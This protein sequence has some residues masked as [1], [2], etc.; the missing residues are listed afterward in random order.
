MERNI[1]RDAG[2]VE[3][4]PEAV[5]IS[6]RHIAAY[7]QRLRECDYEIH[8]L[9][10]IRKKKLIFAAAADPYTLESPHRLLSAAKAIIAA[11]VLFA[12]DEGRLSFDSRIIDFFRTSCLKIMTGVLKGSR[13]MI[14]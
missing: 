7:L 13:Y 4:V 14:F 1:L 11:A 9:Q 3:D 2:V 8:S 10:I 12:I 5:G 6:S